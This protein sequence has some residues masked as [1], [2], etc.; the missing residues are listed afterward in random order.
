MKTNL[1]EANQTEK[2]GLVTVIINS[3]GMSHVV[4]S[5][6]SLLEATRNLIISMRTHL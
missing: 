4:T 6:N 1:Y 3:L 2:K 5:N